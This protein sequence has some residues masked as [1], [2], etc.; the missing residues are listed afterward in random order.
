MAKDI[1]IRE[2]DIKKEQQKEKK[3]HRKFS[4]YK[5]NLLHSTLYLVKR[6]KYNLS[7]TRFIIFASARSGSSLLRNL[8]DSITNVCCEGELLH[9]DV[10]LPSFQIYSKCARSNAEVWGCK[11][12]SYQI[13]RQPTIRN[14]ERFLPYLYKK[15]FKC[16]YLRRENL[17]FHALSHIRARIYGYQEKKT[18]KEASKG[19]I[20]IDPDYILSW[21][22]I[23]ESME[24][25]EKRLISKVPHLSLTYENNLQH[26]KVH[27]STVNNICDFLGIKSSPVTANLRKISPRTL[28]ESL[29]NYEDIQK[30]LSKTQYRK[31]L[32]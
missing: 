9:H 5:N 13:I 30:C 18:S 12:L 14:E 1:K 3:E 28:K 25:Y 6:G 31:Y 23:S 7:P 17:V 8:M 22:K 2:E 32:E 27:Q 16:I 10:L 20:L 24:N 19:G 21:I 26:E 29:T 15:G 11:I 4:V